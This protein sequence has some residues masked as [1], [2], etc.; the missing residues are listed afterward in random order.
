LL[1]NHFY[2]KNT[3]LFDRS[4]FVELKRLIALST[5]S[6]I[7]LRLNNHLARIILYF[8][9]I[10][11]LLLKRSHAFPG[12]RDLIVRQISTQLIFPFSIQN[13][14]GIVVGSSITNDEKLEE[15]HL[16]SA[17]KKIFPEIEGVKGS[18]YLHQAIQEAITLLYIEIR[19]PDG[20]PFNKLQRQ[21]LKTQLPEVLKGH[22]EKLTPT[23]FGVRNAENESKILFLLDKELTHIN[24]LPQ[25]NIN[26][27]K[28]TDQFLFFTISL[29]YSLLLSR[30]TENNFLNRILEIPKIRCEKTSI[31]GYLDHKYPKEAAIF[32]LKIP[33]NKEI[34]RPDFSINLP[35][36]REKV[37]SLLQEKIG[38][39]R[40][41]NGGF[42]LKQNHL[43]T[44]LKKTKQP[45]LEVTSDFIENFFF[46]LSPIEHQATL[47]LE[48]L[49]KL[50]DLV[51]E[52]LSNPFSKH[53][54]TLFRSLEYKGKVFIAIKSY[55]DSIHE[56]FFDYLKNYSVLM[57][58]L[59]YTRF[60][61]HMFYITA[62]IFLPNHKI[63]KSSFYKILGKC[64]EACKKNQILSRTLKLSIANSPISLDPRL[65]GEEVSS[66]I[67]KLLFEGLM[68]INKDG[69]PEYAIAKNVKISNDKKSYLFTLRESFWSDGTPLSAQ[70][71]E[72]SWKRILSPDFH[73][74]FYYFFYPIKNARGVKQGKIPIESLGVK[75]LNDLT[76]KV[77]L[78]T[79]TPYF[80][81][82]ICYNLYA[83]VSKSH[84]LQN[85]NWPIQERENYVCNGPFQIEQQS[86]KR[87]L[88]SRNQYYWNYRKI[89]LEKVIISK[90]TNF[91]AL[92]A[93]EQNEID[94]LG[95]PLHPWDVT[96]AIKKDRNVIKG[97]SGS[98]ILWLACNT[99]DRYLG[100]KNLRKA[101]SFSISRK[102][103]IHSLNY[104]GKIATSILPLVHASYF[105]KRLEEKN[106]TLA[107][108]YYKA[109]LSDLGINSLND[110]QLKIFI[111]H[112]GIREK[113]I[114]NVVEQWRINLGLSCEIILFDW[115]DLFMLMRNG[116]FQIA[117]TMWKPLINNPMYT[118]DVFKEK[119][120][121]VN[122]SKWE[123]K[124]YNAIF[125][126][127]L[128]NQAK[129]RK[130]EALLMEHLPVIPLIYEEQCYV[131]SPNLQGYYSSEIGRFDFKEAFFQQEI[132]T[133]PSTKEDIYVHDTYKTI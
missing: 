120:H 34:T 126:S 72:Y 77:E 48:D 64:F 21:K 59:S 101:L 31:T 78:E 112:G 93:F 125:Q 124:K 108:E 88:L 110:H 123:S 26:F 10:R 42:L 15:K 37:V 51:S 6:F 73:T 85:P 118:L 47:P 16:L 102:H 90:F 44:E 9:Y 89:H 113:I 14:M 84:D 25:V 80:L 61:H 104:P 114:N 45:F 127:N 99:Q 27:E 36:A 22:V 18:F 100:N 86:S 82:L 109:A 92:K 131:K 24:D 4:L 28:Q 3:H 2:K 54:D 23:L 70:D 11:W 66:T 103:I 13:V 52:V 20:Q 19:N 55:Q 60:T 97:S 129:Y 87:Y 46:N 56:S 116:D 62:M 121:P 83:P 39:F 35:H 111:S 50:Y 115:K 58:S 32:T 5:E 75:A 65:G 74:P 57:A 96:F 117:G 94:W 41:Y 29:I 105:D 133:R 91:L 71:F 122:F 49:S 107:K 67:L 7:D 98:E 53:S 17:C 43:F 40:D 33:I 8:N 69:K 76:L 30:S 95:A 128:I 1:L 81:D 63:D 68:S 38:P 12:R 132:S 106:A 130:A 119:K 79:P